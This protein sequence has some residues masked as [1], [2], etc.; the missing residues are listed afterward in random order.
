MYIHDAARAFVE[1]AAAPLDRIQTANYIVLGPVPFPTAQELVKTVTTKIPGARLDFQVN[2]KVSDLIETV[3]ARPFEDK[4]ARQ[5]WGWQHQY[6][7][8][9][10][11]DE[12]MAHVKHKARA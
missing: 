2:H 10:I 8:E 11:V 9:G 7:V 1:L 5:E 12:F 6:S 3:T 4:Y